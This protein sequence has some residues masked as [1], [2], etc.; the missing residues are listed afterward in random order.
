MLRLPEARVSPTRPQQFLVRAEFDDA[1]LVQHRDLIRVHDGGE[2]VSDHQRR[3]A[4]RQRLQSARDLAFRV[5]VQGGGGL[6]EHVDARFQ[7]RNPGD[8]DALPLA[9]RQ[10]HAALAY[11]CLVAGWQRADQRAS[12]AA[13][14]ASSISEAVA[15]GLPMAML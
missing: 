6:V 13:C 12:W 11:D 4:P 7:K 14:A 10:L 2:P 5:T 15:P 9:P 3:R 1:A 8:A